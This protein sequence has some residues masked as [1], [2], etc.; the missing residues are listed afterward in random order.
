V[1]PLA[2]LPTWS[3][4][5]TRVEPGRLAPGERGRIVVA[6]EVP[7]GCHIQSHT[8]AEPFLIPTTLDLD[9]A[10]GLTFGPARYPVG[11]TER[12][13]WTPVVLAVYRGRVE[14]DVPVAAEAGAKPGRRTVSGRIRYQGCTANACLP[15]AEM[16]IAVDLEIASKEERT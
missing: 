9:E 14:I 12:F 10:P 8:P 15:P 3:A 6:L 1:T 13:D 11:D 7:E 5:S 4:P 16:D 2:T